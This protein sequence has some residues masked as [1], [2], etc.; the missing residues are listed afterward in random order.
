MSEQPYEIIIGLEVHVQLATGTKLFCRC[1][2]QFGDPPNTNTCPVCIGLPGSLPVMNREA[3]QLGLKT[4]VAL[5]CDIP[6]F[7]KWDRKNYYYPDLPKGYQ[8]SQFDL[9]MSQNGY[10]AISDP[11]GQF[12]PKRIGIIRAHLEEDAGKSM[13]DEVAG[14]AD[15]R[16]DLNRTGT[17]LLEIVS[18]PDIRSPLEAKAYLTELKLLLNYLGVSD[19][20]MQEGSLRVDANIN[21]HLEV[22]GEKVATPIVEVKNMNSFR[23]VERAM[24]YEAQRQYDVWRE[25]G[26]RIGDVP[27]QTRGWDDPAQVTRAQRHK[28]ESSDYRYFPDPDLVPVIVT[29]EETEAVRASLGELPAA[30]RGRLEQSYGITPYDADVIVNQG[31][32]FADYFTTLADQC[33]D[34]KLAANWATQ[35]VLRTLNEQTIDISQ[36]ARTVPAARLVELLQAVRAGHVDTSRGRDVLARMHETGESAAKAMKQ[37]GIEQVDESAT[38]ELCRQLLA[39]NPKILADIQAGKTKAAGALIGMAKQKNPNVDPQQVRKTCL[40]L[41]QQM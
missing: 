35:S 5:N 2:T 24:A 21:L 4:A 14:K 22:D 31:R 12:E 29:E 17:P 36:Y 38:V 13:H 10:L 27:K 15:S 20:N 9:P 32:A 28:E 26:Q 30:L 37:L 8:I 11:K 34:G 33:G 6:R 3:F 1:R 18:Q 25:T 19:C 41:A 40:E 23:A 16:I 39:E 7:T